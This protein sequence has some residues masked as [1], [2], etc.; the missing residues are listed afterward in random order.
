M[1]ELIKE[2]V[3]QKL[4]CKV[5]K[6]NFIGGGSFGRVYKVILSN[7]SMVAVK[8]YLK[9]SVAEN[10]AYALDLLSKISGVKVPEVYFTVKHTDDIRHDIICMELIKG[11]NAFTNLSLLFANRKNKKQFAKEV[12]AG[13]NAIHSVKNDKFGFVNDAVFDTWNDFY[14]PF[15]DDIYN[16]AVR[17]NRNG[18]FDKYILDV[19]KEAI[20]RYD[21]IF[22]EKV[23]EAVLIHGDL[24]VMNIMVDKKFK[25]TGFIDPL[26]TMYA[27]R[28]YELF[29]LTNLTG[30]I[31]NLLDEYKAVNKVS[32]N[33][34]QKCA[35]YSLWNEAMVYLKTGK[36][37]SFIMKSAVK[38]MKK[39]LEWI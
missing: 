39:E 25:L 24:N 15:A 28:E 2:Q 14:K 10:E 38:N 23:N 16:Q 37:T 36:Y 20:S 4:N 33:L 17:A 3:N 7:N 6:I 27:D 8:V 9:S 11:R 13:I 5:K 21:L 35:F 12:I 30:N 1:K 26:N 18:R 19:M 29:Q 22:N 31:F 32:D 34:S